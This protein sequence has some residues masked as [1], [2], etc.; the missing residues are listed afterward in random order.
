MRD[1][2]AGD[3]HGV[4]VTIAGLPGEPGCC[5]AAPG[6]TP[7][8]FVARQAAL[9]EAVWVIA[10]E[11]GGLLLALCQAVPPTRWLG[12]SA[13]ALAVASSKGRT[14]ARLAAAGVPVPRE[15]L[16]RQG[17]WVL[18]PDDGAGAV[19]TRVQP[20][21]LLAVPPGLRAEPWVEGEPMSLS[22]Q[23]RRHDALLLSVNR[24]Q[25]TVAGDGD[26]LVDA[27]QPA[28]WRETDPRWPGLQRLA[29]Q[30]VA[31]VPG[32]RGFVGIDFVWHPEAGPVVIE[33]NPRATSALVGLSAALGRPVARAI[34]QGWADER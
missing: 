15:G 32:L 30:V 27:P 13:E 7:A 28:V 33:V 26:V 12:S 2:I 24:Q 1:A 22:V 17:R 21:P 34:V 5:S 8:A 3:L 6:E 25:V 23:V 19:A 31:A 20:G 11:T 4:P 9:H 16:D 18:K 14:V 29:R 10:P